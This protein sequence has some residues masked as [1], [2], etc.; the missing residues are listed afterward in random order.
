[1]EQNESLRY[2]RW[3]MN[4]AR[5]TLCVVSLVLLVFSLFSG[6]E[7][8]GNG[9]SALVKNS[10]NAL[11]WIALFVL[12]LIA[13]KRHIF[14]G[15]LV[16]V[17]GLWMLYFYNFR[18]GNFFLTTFIITMLIPLLGFIL[19]VTGYYLKKALPGHE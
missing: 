4:F 7:A 1:M 6:A 10:P 9:L 5:Y 15:F 2:V 8:Y 17:I 19:I 11:P 14:G 18:G 16:V 13:C 12:S 3:A